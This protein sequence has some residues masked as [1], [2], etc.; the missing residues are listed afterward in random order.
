LSCT[1]SGAHEFGRT[2]FCFG[3]N[4]RWQLIVN[5]ENYIETTW[6]CSFTV[7]PKD[8]VIGFSQNPVELNNS[9]TIKCESRGF[10][11]PSYKITLND[12]KT[13]SSDKTHTI[14]NVKLNDAGTYTCTATNT[15]GSD[16]DS[17]FLV[18]TGKMKFTKVENTYDFPFF[19]AY[20]IGIV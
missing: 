3:S 9:V 12:T 2:L 15:N 6:V 14:H 20:I 1:E 7:K 19:W 4:F 13:V 5:V 16:S 10:P 8:T 18:V 17:M 11:P